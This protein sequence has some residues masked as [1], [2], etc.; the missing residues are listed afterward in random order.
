MT[1]KVYV[2]REELYKKR[3]EIIRESPPK[4][5]YAQKAFI[6]ERIAEAR[7]R[8]PENVEKYLYIYII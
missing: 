5:V 7:E 3:E 8:R 6:K 4:R 2:Q 1:P